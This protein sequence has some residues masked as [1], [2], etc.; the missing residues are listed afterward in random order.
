MKPLRIA[1]GE[2]NWFAAELLRS[3]VADLGHV[4]VGAA[5]TGQELIALVARERPDL[6]LVD[7]RLAR[8]S[9][10]LAA[11]REIGSRLDVPAIAASGHL[12]AAE[13]R[14]AGFVGVLRKPYT[15]AA[16]KAVLTAAADWLERPDR[17]K[18]FILR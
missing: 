8:D 15:T 18:P 14:A 7:V 10:G 9:G 6:A 17:D 5:G 4:V 3:E 2:D 13:A 12:E 1:I 16:L 11:A